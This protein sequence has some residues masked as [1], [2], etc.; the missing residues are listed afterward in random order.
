MPIVE[1]TIEIQAPIA[2]VFAFV[3][4][5]RNHG[6]VAPPET[7]ERLLDAGDVPLRVGSVVKFSARY[8]LVRWTLSSR[9]TDVVSLDPANPKCASFQ[10]R[11]LRGPF[12]VWIHDHIYESTSNAGTK[13]TDRFT[14]EA[15]FGPFGRIADRIWLHARLRSMMVYFQDT[16]KRILEDEATQTAC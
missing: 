7:D 6:R 11:Q 16:E 9:V 2:Q 1:R 4:D 5:A 12:A 14:Y 8:G 10:D 13:V 3:T 15:P